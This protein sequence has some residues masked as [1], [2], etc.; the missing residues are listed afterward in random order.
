MDKQWEEID[1][2]ERLLCAGGRLCDTAA[3]PEADFTRTVFDS[4]SLILPLIECG[5]AFPRLCAYIDVPGDGVD[6]VAF[7]TMYATHIQEY[8]DTE[9]CTVGGPVEDMYRCGVEPVRSLT[10]RCVDS[11]GEPVRSLRSEDVHAVILD[12]TTSVGD[13]TEVSVVDGTVRLRYTVEEDIVRDS[14]DVSISVYGRPCFI[15]T[16][17]VC[18]I[19]SVPDFECL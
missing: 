1:S 12:G 16:V 3:I 7:E 2:M 13:V 6:G 14:L 10:V 15:H 8:I 19:A 17:K 18:D 5:T 4:M 11:E 9:E